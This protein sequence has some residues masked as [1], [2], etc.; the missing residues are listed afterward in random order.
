MTD[1]EF[2]RKFQKAIQ[3]VLKQFEDNADQRNS[4]VEKASNN[5][6]NT[7][8]SVAEMLMVQNNQT[9]EL[10]LNILKASLREM[11]VDEK[12]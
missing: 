4:E 11:M 7:I 5:A 3:P 8:E 2:N 1:E 9:A 6:D 12:E 10:I